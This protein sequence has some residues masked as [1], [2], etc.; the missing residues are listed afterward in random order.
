MAKK[1]MMVQNGIQATINNNYG[2]LQHH[3]FG[4]RHDVSL[5]FLY[6]LIVSGLC[7]FFVEAGNSKG[8][9]PVGVFLC[10]CWSFTNNYLLP[11]FFT[12][13]YSS[14]ILVLSCK[15]S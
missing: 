14:F 10:L 3:I 15:I 7:S 9:F 4:E 12:S 1:V 2:S 11:S 8:E 6:F 5:L 13:K